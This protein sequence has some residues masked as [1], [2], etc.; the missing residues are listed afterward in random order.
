MAARQQQQQGAPAQGKTYQFKLV[1][2]GNIYGDFISFAA[3]HLVG[4]FI[5][6]ASI[7]PWQQPL[8][9]Y[10]VEISI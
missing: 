4:G 1:L 10:I 3:L 5:M 2:L 7:Y 9:N 6:P 8:A